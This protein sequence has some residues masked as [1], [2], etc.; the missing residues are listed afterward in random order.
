MGVALLGKPC[1]DKIFENVSKGLQGRNAALYTLGFDDPQWKQYVSSLSRNAEKCGVNVNAVFLRPDVSAQTLCNYVKEACAQTDAVGVLVEQP[2]P[3][4][5]RE[6]Y[7]FIDI[8]LDVDCL[9]PLSIAALY[10]NKSGFRPATPSAVVRLLD[11]YGVELE[12]KHVVIIGRGGV[13]KPLALMML[14]RNATV[15][16]C[17]S[18]TVNLAEVCRSADVLVSACGVPS[19]V[20]NEFVTEKTVVVDVG[21]NFDK[22]KTCGD[23]SSDCTKCSAISPVPGGVGPVTRAILFENMLKAFQAK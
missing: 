17:H 7:S 10:G 14:N 6:A 12:G 20:T 18:K 5:Y 9:N 15:T 16:V 11:F 4:V 8:S 1:A 22:G 2:L 3:V 21:L 23:V 13:G 19:L